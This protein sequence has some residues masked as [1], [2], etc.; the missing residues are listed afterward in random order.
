[1]A[2]RSKTI[3]PTG[4]SLNGGLAD[5]CGLLEGE[6]RYAR[7]QEDRWDIKPTPRVPAPPWRGP[8]WLPL[9]GAAVPAS[10]GRTGGETAGSIR[11]RAGAS[12]AVLQSEPASGRPER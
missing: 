2:G 5:V 11:G 3:L 9:P 12:R 8:P 1:M 4:K 6:A 7:R 10:G